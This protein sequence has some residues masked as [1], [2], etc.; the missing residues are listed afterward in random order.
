VEQAHKFI[1]DVDGTLTPSRGK[2]DLEFKT[3]FDT[4][5]KLNDVYLVTGS[6][7]DKTIEQISEETYNL[8][9]RVYN[10][11]GNDVYEKDQHIRSAQF[12]PS[13]ELCKFMHSWLNTSSFP[14]RTGNHIEQRTGTLNFSIIGRNCTLGERMLYVKHD[15]ANRERESIAFQINLDFP[16]VSATVGG[17][18]GIDIYK[19]GADKSQ[20]LSDFESTDKIYFFGDKCEQGGNDFPIAQRLDTKK[21]CNVKDWKDTYERLQYFQEAKLAA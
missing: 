7:R 1:F 8:C 3:F 18:T 20:I 17:E 21:V 19:K 5:C 2:I 9:Q 4:F 15:L 16:E 10:C 6:D 14:L 12:W 13:K 11:S